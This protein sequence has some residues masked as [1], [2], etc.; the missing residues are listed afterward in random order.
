M[1]SI[2]YK[3]YTNLHKYAII[4]LC[5]ILCYKFYNL[6]LNT[7]WYRSVNKELL[8]TIKLCILKRRKLYVRKSKH[9]KSKQLW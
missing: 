8:C 1:F 9:S 7:N 6:A 3:V 5:I 2:I 4:I